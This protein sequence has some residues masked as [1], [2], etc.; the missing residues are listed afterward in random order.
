MKMRQFWGQATILN[1]SPRPTQITEWRSIEKCQTVF[2]FSNLQ[3][4]IHQKTVWIGTNSTNLQQERTLRIKTKKLM[5]PNLQ[6]QPWKKLDHR[7]RE[8]AIII[9][10]IRVFWITVEDLNRWQERQLPQIGMLRRCKVTRS[11]PKLAIV[12]WLQIVGSV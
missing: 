4:N 5:P 12:W 8:P 9:K 6:C 3:P 11:W 1:N 2:Q 10:P 7:L